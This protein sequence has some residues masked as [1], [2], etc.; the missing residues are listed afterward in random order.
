MC[1]CSLVAREGIPQSAPALACWTRKTLKNCQ[2]LEKKFWVRVPES[3]VSVARKLNT[4]AKGCQDQNCL[5]RRGDCGNKGHNPET[6]L[7]LRPGEDG[8]VARKLSTI[9]TVTRPECSVSA[10]RSQEQRSYPITM[11]FVRVMVTMVELSN[12]FLVFVRKLKRRIFT[13]LS[14]WRKM[15]VAIVL[16]GF[17]CAW[18]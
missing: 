16:P 18:K 7:G 8:F 13:V 9:K 2:N 6:V 10:G 11:V 1:A 15:C 5:L 14:L 12:T 3:V 17:S 4:I